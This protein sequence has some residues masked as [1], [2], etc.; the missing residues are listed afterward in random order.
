LTFPSQSKG[1]ARVGEL[2]GMVV[3]FS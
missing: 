3:M 2:E 1:L